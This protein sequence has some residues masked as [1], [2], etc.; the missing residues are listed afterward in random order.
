MDRPR[1]RSPSQAS[2]VGRPES[3]SRSRSSRTR[4]ESAVPV[5]AETLSMKDLLEVPQDPSWEA[6][7]TKI[8][9]AKQSKLSGDYEA[10]LKVEMSMAADAIGLQLMQLNES[11]MDLDS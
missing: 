5:R 9:S 8:S 10:S 2:S 3:A 7:L 1:L 11:F 6:Y 4:E